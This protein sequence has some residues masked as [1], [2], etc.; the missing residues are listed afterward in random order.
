MASYENER[1]GL[2]IGTGLGES[3]RGLHRLPQGVGRGLL[4]H[5]AQGFVRGGRTVDAQAP[6]GGG[7]HGKRDDMARGG[8]AAR[9]RLPDTHEDRHLQ[10]GRA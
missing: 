3:H 8:R 6:A 4:D 1:H 7:R 2:R 5:D 10:G 9:G